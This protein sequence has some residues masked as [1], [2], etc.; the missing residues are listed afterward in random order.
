MEINLIVGNNARP[1]K[2]WGKVLSWIGFEDK[3]SKGNLSSTN[4]GA[5]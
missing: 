4:L 1:Q 3:S 5:L 2:N